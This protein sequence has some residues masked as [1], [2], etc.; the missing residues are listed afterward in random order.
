MFPKP[1]AASIQDGIMIFLQ[2]CLRIII[3]PVTELPCMIMQSHTAV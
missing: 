2:I 3:M 1:L